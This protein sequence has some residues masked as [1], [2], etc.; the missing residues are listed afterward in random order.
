MNKDLQDRLRR[1]GVVKGPRKL[2]P[3][4]PKTL[5][6]KIPV[7]QEPEAD[8]DYD[9][10]A[11]EIPT[12]DTLLPGGQLIETEYGACFVLDKVYPATYQHGQ[13]QLSDLLPLSLE[14]A[15]VFNQD[16]RLAALSHQDFLFID[17]ET[18]G[19]MGAG[20]IA[21]MVGAAFWGWRCFC[22]ASIFLA[23]SRRRTSHAL[24]SG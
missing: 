11:E 7:Y 16:E 14:T 15:A 5:D 1:L 10:A 18:T 19:L 8:Y 13:D 24:S 21:F 20:T 12:L 22:C 17:T 23:R 4:E 6:P 2:K 3:V 9:T